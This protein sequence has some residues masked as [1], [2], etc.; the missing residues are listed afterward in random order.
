MTST[1]RPV[2]PGAP[3]PGAAVVQPGEESVVP[4]RYRG[5]LL[6]NAVALLGGRVV[7]AALG[8]AGTL[9]VVRSLSAEQWGRFSFV[10]ALLGLLSFATDLSSSRVLVVAL[11]RRDADR[12][13]LAGTYVCLRALLGVAAYL[14][15]VAFVVLAGY[16]RDI[17]QATALG[18]LVLVVGAAGG[19]LDSVFQAEMRQG[20]VAL[21]DVL[22]QIVQLALTVA[23]ATTHPSLLWFVLPALAFDV[24]G[25]AWKAVAVRLLVVPRL[26]VQLGLWASLLRQA[27]P[28]ALGAALFLLTVQ[29]PV[30]L[31][32][33]L[34][35][36]GFV[37]VGQYT[38]ALKF[39]VLGA[40]L[41]AALTSPLLPLLVRSWPVD[42]ALFHRTVS[43]AVLLVTVGGGLVAAG[44][45]P[46]MGEVVSLLYGEAYRGS[47]TSATVLL[48]ASCLGFA[49]PVGV[50]VLITVGRNRA[51]V[52]LGLLYLTVVVGGTVLLAPRWSYEGA[53]VAAAAGEVVTLLALLALAA[54]AGALGVLPLRA[55]CGV[56]ASAATSAVLGHV[57]AE[58]LPWP[59]AAAAALALDLVL[60]QTLCLTRE[61]GLRGLL[62][63]GRDR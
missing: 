56:A 24:V 2:R 52:V 38:V 57:A 61:G 47:A 7:V 20:H 21:G 1:S 33:R 18:G 8:W 60:V 62:L 40:F 48:A 28:L 45:L 26:N 53:A 37:A 49:T 35:E 10:F 5:G 19:A 29:A 14:L 54:R 63:E 42:R 43:R 22:G 32:S 36:D 27:A 50:V 9:V 34:R 13:R 16:P 15:A 25:V 12:A 3:G 44:L 6:S 4:A 39:V 58:L 31:L 41:P 17:V 51:Y 30:V 46:V 59:V 55:S 11:T 23:V